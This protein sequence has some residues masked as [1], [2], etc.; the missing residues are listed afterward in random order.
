MNNYLFNMKKKLSSDLSER[1]K[2]LIKSN[3][4]S[5]RDF[6][7]KVGINNNTV[8]NIIN[9]NNSPNH[10]VVY[11]IL[12]AIPELSAEWFIRGEGQMWKENISP[13]NA[14]PTLPNKDK[15]WEEMTMREMGELLKKVKRL[16]Q[17]QE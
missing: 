5:R 8:N 4:S 12:K 2:F 11:K 14:R 1:L 3:Y 15:D 17:G 9:N 7:T 10:S 16:D 6:A 13:P